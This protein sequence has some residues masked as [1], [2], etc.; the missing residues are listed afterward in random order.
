MDAAARAG[1]RGRDRARAVR[2]HD[3]CHRRADDPGHPRAGRPRRSCWAGGAS[4][5]RQRAAPRSPPQWSSPSTRRRSCCGERHLGRLHQARRHRHVD[6]PH[7]PRVRVRA[8]GRRPGALDARRDHRRLPGRQLPDRRLRGGRGDVGS[9]PARTSRS[10]CS[11]RWRSAPPPSPCWSIELARRQSSAVDLPALI[12]MLLRCRRCSSATSLW[13]GVKEVVSAALLAL[14][15][16][17]AADRGAPRVAARILRAGRGRRGRPRRRPGARR[18]PLGGADPAV[19][20]CGSCGEA[21]GCRRRGGSPGRSPSSRSR[22]PC[23][24]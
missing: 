14:A 10:R 6:G 1:S 8:R 18:G 4:D 11:R 2:H 24:S 13:G 5:P 16:A 23:R 3:G 17:V 19:P 9:P 15:P 7:R 22:S 21:W 12:A 20:P